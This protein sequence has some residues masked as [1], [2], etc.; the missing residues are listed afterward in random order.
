MVAGS[1]KLYVRF[2]P[3]HTK[4]LADILLYY[5]KKIQPIFVLMGQCLKLRQEARLSAQQ[6][7]L[8]ICIF[9]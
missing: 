2:L 1:G 8:K 5:R 9:M 4:S 6:R 7:K 3:T